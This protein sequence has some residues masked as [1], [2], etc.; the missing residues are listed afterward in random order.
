LFALA[1]LALL[2]ALVA[3]PVAAAPPADKGKPG[4]PPG[5]GKKAAKAKGTKKAKAPKQRAA[6]A[7]ALKASSRPAHSPPGLADK[8]RAGARGNPP[9][10]ANQATAA[11]A[12]AASASGATAQAAQSARAARRVRA[13]AAARRRAT[14]ARRREV[15]TRRARARRVAAAQAFE[16][17]AG[18]GLASDT[19]SDAADR[20]FAAD[21]PGDA[22]GSEFVPIGTANE[23]EA[24]EPPQPLRV[25]RDI[26]EV[27]PTP[28]RVLLA[29]LA[30]LSI[31]LAMASLLTLLRNRR[32]AEQR[33]ELLSDVGLL[34]AAL[35]P[36]LPKGLAYCRAS[37]AYRPADGPGA[38]GDFY[39]VLALTG[40]RTAVII[41]DVSGH[42]RAALARTALS[43]YTLRAYVEAGLEPRE[44]LQIAGSV[45]AGKL[46]GDFVTALVAVHDPAAATLTYA[47]AGHPPPIVVTEGG[48]DPVVVG[49]APPLG[50]GAGTGQRQTTV[51]FPRGAVACFYTDGLAEARTDEGRLGTERLAQ[52]VHELG[53]D[54]TAEQVIDRVAESARTITDDAAVCVLAAEAGAGIVRGRVERLEITRGELRGPLL[55]GFLDACGVSPHGVRATQRDAREVAQRTGGALIEVRMGERPEVDV[56]QPEIPLGDELPLRDSERTRV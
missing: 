45:L 28:V 34:Q 21:D 14:A 26:V 29:A 43:R 39:D 38:G 11:A 40:G 48:F 56:R 36:E 42:G 13:A 32:L 54:L 9:V 7:K 18:S 49:T 1:C 19:S 20:P 22:D 37:V 46:E 25:V 4:A 3:W 15:A 8:P 35:L 16:S 55:P 27:V 24:S 50:A 47:T 53:P 17:S 33:R 10:Q 31:I 6:Q 30:A 5:Q 23:P 2:C 41:G 12:A 44:T 52:L 51:P